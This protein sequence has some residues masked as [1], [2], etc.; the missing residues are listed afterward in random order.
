M[1]PIECDD[2]GRDCDLCGYNKTC[3]ERDPM[4]QE[5]EGD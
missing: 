1:T 2:M 4:H 5:K 3:E